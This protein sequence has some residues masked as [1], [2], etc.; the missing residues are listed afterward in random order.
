MNKTLITLSGPTACGKTDLSIRIAK[1]LGAEIFS[2]DSRQFYKEMSIG[3]AVPSETELKEIPHHFIQHKSIQSPYSVGQF[4]TDAM[5]ALTQYFEKQ[6]FAILVGG[7][8]LY[9]HAVVE[10]IDKFPEVPEEIRTALGQRL[11]TNGLEEL[12]QELQS[13]DPDHFQKIDIQNPSRVLRAL[14][15]SLA[16]GQPYSSFLGQDKPK[17]PFT[18]LPLTVDISRELLYNR[19]NERVDQMIKAGLLQEAES[20]YPYRDRNALQ[21]V[22]YQEIFDFIDRKIDLDEAIAQIKQHTR[23][24]AKRQMTW[25]RRKESNPEQ[26]NPTISDEDLVSILPKQP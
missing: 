18:V 7:S 6:D 10:G 13:L 23:N 11:E 26:I 14:G 9:M 20:L 22:G 5:D 21:T 16:A 19:I 24:Y 12:K 3:T 4:E 25:I 2:C 8:G 15:V 17:R 1:I